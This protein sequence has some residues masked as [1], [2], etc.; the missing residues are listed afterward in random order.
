MADEVQVPPAVA[1]PDAPAWRSQSGTSLPE[2]HGS[3]LIPH[4]APQKG[5]LQQF[6]KYCVTIGQKYGAALDFAPLPKVVEA[7]AL[8]TIAAL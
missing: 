3:I 1:S 8:K 4:D 5:F 2:V 7:A 6:T